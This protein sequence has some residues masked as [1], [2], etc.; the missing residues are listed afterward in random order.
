MDTWPCMAHKPTGV[1]WLVDDVNG[2]GDQITTKKL[3]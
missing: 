1:G 2:G 3:E